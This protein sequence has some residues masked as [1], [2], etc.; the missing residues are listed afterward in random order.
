MSIFHSRVKD[1]TLNVRVTGYL[2]KDP[3]VTDKVVLFSVCYGKKKYMDCKAWTSDTPGQIAACMEHHDFVSVDGVFQP[4]T[5]SDG[6]TRDQITV[7]GIFPMNIPFAAPADVSED[8]LPPS[9]TTYEEMM[10]TG[11]GELSF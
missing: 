3:K 9:S 1:G 6:Q 5:G 8:D 2:T 11:D 10:D 4:Y 7:D